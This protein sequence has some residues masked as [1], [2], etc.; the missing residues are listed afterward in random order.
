MAPWRGRK[1]APLHRAQ[2]ETRDER[3]A[4]ARFDLLDLDAYDMM[5]VQYSRGC[6][7]LC[8]FCDIINLYGRVPRTK[9]HRKAAGGAADGSTIWAGAAAC[10]WSTT[11]SSATRRT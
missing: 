4:L 11:T 8:E 6:P 10:S 5:S 9:P 2:Q 7:F 1:G 3:D